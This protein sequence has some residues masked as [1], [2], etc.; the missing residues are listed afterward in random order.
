MRQH[1]DHHDDVSDDPE[2]D[3]GGQL[4]HMGPTM[5][6]ARGPA[7]LQI[8]QAELDQAARRI[9]YVATSAVGL[10]GATAWG[11]FEAA[12]AAGNPSLAGS[13]AIG[14][15]VATGAGLPLLRLRLRDRRGPDD[16]T[17]VRIPT[18]YRRRWWLAGVAGTAWIDAMAAGVASAVGPG[19]M[20]ALLV[21]GAAALSA[22]WMRDHP[23]P[24][25]VDP[26]PPAPP[27]PPPPA[28]RVE[29]PP[30]PPPPDEG[31]LIAEMWETRVAAGDNAVAPG[32]ELGDDRVDL[33]NGYQWTVQFDPNGAVRT[34][35]LRD[36]VGDIA[37]KLGTRVAHVSIDHLE[38]DDQ[39][40]DRALLTV[41]TRNVV[42]DGVPY[43]GPIYQDDKI[44]LGMFVDGSGTPRWTAVDNTG[45]QF[46]VVVGASG[47][48]K[49]ELLARLAMG[50]RKSGKWLVAFGDG[51]PQGRSSPLLKRVAWDFA[52]GPREILEQLE[53][54]EAWFMARGRLMG[55]LTTDQDGRPVPMTDPARQPPVAKMMPCRDYPGLLWI[56][57]EL[58]RSADDP[59][60]QAARFI[61]RLGRAG[62]EIRKAGGA[63]V[64]GTQ[65]GTGA[66]FGNDEELRAQLTSGNL[67]LMRTTNDNTQYALGHFGCDPSELPKG[68]GYGFVRDEDGR[69]TM[70]RGERSPHMD[71]WVQTLPEYRPDR[72]SA[73]V[74][75]A[76]RTPK[77]ADPIRDYEQYQQSMRELEDALASGDRLPWEEPDDDEQETEEQAAE[78]TETDS[79]PRWTTGGVSIAQARLGPMFDN[80]PVQQIGGG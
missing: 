16:C 77:P 20:L 32:S 47:S 51:D 64:I 29:L 58:Y 63:I 68:G 5:V 66:D 7:V 39:R 49:S 56:L 43:Q 10:T 6:V 80:A 40:E 45:P 18:D 2:E 69:Q 24:P 76:K 4:E 27:L 26:P 70:F 23:V 42:R 31:D 30:P 17:Y 21:G 52:P 11:L 14:T 71:R 73:K 75:A 65:A 48:G 28:P 44:P 53:A 34:T 15:W 55:G 9:P 13:I 74:Y 37:L 8:R 41:I 57:D 12:V 1:L 36:R 79:P 38:G 61:P 22:R 59:L 67:V 78:Q 62:R 25:P 60:L 35:L 72:L 50:Y 54:V 3:A 33:P 19:P 46:G